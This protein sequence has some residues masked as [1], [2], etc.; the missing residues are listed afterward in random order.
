MCYRTR[1]DSS[2]PWHMPKIY[3]HKLS[4]QFCL[5]M[6][7]QLQNL[8]TTQF[9]WGFTKIFSTFLVKVFSLC[10]KQYCIITMAAAVITTRCSVLSKRGMYVLRFPHFPD[11]ISVQKIHFKGLRFCSWTA[12]YSPAPKVIFA[13]IQLHFAC[14]IH[15]SA[16]KEM[17][18][19]KQK[20]HILSVG[21]LTNQFFHHCLQ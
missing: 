21:S 13:E 19:T 11:I 5:P 4:A 20:M 14:W 9:C 18:L 3:Q 12:S 7:T 1:E 8:V 10:H 17:H 16:F 2:W 15:S 6:N